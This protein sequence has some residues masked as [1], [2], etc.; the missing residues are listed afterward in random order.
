VQ[1]ISYKNNTTA[2]A[3]A[4]QVRDLTGQITSFNYQAATAPTPAASAS[5]QHDALLRRTQMTREDGS[6]WD[7]GYNPRGEVASAVR[8][9]SNTN[10]VPLEDFSYSYDALGNP[11]T[12]ANGTRVQKFVPNAANQISS[13]TTPS[14]L[15]ITGSAAAN[16]SVQVNST[17]TQRQG[18]YFWKEIPVA[19]SSSGLYEQV[20]ATSTQPGAGP[21]GTDL[22]QS[23][24]SLLY[25]Q[26]ASQTL[27]YDADGNLT[28]DTRWDYAWDAENRLMSMTER[29]TSA[30][31][32][33]HNPVRK[34]LVFHYTADGRRMAKE[35]FTWT[36][37]A[38]TLQDTYRYAFHGWQMVYI[39]QTS[40]TGGYSA[41]NHYLWGLDLSGSAEGAGTAGGLL[42]A[43]SGGRNIA[44]T[45]ATNLGDH[46]HIPTHD[47]NAN[48]STLLSIQPD[49]SLRTEATYQYDAFGQESANTIRSQDTN[50]QP[51]PFR[52]SG[53]YHDAETGLAYYG[54]RYYSPELGRWLNRDPIE[55]EG[56]VNLYGMVGN[57]VVN[58]IDVLGL[59]FPPGTPGNF[60]FPGFP[61]PRKPSNLPQ[62][63]G[64]YEIGLDYLLGTGKTNY[65]FKDG[66]YMTESLKT[67]D[68]FAGRREQMRIMLSSYCKAGGKGPLPVIDLGGELGNI[69]WYKF[70]FWTFP[71]TLVFN[72]PEAFTGSF[73]AGQI[74][75]SSID[76][77]KCIATLHVSAFNNSGAV[78]NTRFPP[79]MGGYDNNPSVQRWLSFIR[80]P[81][82]IFHFFGEDAMHSITLDK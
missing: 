6:K 15:P 36:G 55:E 68:L 28:Q 26:P 4:T 70:A 30:A 1:G 22:V 44:G 9:F 14:Y 71:K 18:E 78:S 63:I 39:A 69:P 19:N 32:A 72:P 21:G 37:S 52:F 17:S 56:G 81:V 57:D 66:D 58:H 34:R 53:K 13:R 5:Y 20:Q 40:T 11:L 3:T 62:N 31:T 7:Y 65:N 50:A 48:V 54:F 79:F 47:A 43:I 23:Q 45:W 42:Y 75:V 10:T 8:K 16:A 35:I 76:C 2:L 27:A 25:V 41:S 80:G 49:S 77:S 60:G 24:N 64:A 61:D 73:T 12:R 59:L 29:A 33:A 74:T 82:D 51:F 38:W 67:S 46:N